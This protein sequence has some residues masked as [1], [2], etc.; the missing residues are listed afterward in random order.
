MDKWEITYMCS[1]VVAQER[2]HSR[3][4]PDKPRNAIGAPTTC[5]TELNED[6][7]SSMFRF[8]HDTERDHNNH[9]ADNMQHARDQ[10]GCREDARTPDIDSQRICQDQPIEQ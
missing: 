6:V 1:S 5:V 3:Q 4:Q 9:K 2:I 10:I 7:V 8:S